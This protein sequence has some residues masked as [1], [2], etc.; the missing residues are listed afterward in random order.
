MHCFSTV[1]HVAYN[2]GVWLALEIGLNSLNTD[3]LNIPWS[4]GT[5]GPF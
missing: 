1:K 3:E 5:G 2:H 4:L